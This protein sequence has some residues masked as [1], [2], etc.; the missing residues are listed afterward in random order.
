MKHNDTDVY[1]KT[2][3]QSIIMMSDVKFTNTF[4]KNIKHQDIQ[5]EI[6][7]ILKKCRLK[8][9][10]DLT[11]YYILIIIAHFTNTFL[12]RMK[13]NDTDVYDIFQNVIMISNLQIIFW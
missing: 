2:M 3:F 6:L 10:W 13:N 12:T 1:D 7:K 4:L 11:S 8:I 9:T 5:N